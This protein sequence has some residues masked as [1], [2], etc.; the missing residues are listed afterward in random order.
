MLE[1]KAVSAPEIFDKI[2]GFIRSIPEVEIRHA[3]LKMNKDNWPVASL[4]ILF[5]DNRMLYLKE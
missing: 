3:D 5:L 4:E 2:I 1:E